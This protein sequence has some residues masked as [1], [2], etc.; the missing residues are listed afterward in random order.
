MHSH[1]FLVGSAHKRNAENEVDA[2][3]HGG[4]KFRAI[5][6][7]RGLQMFHLHL[8]RGHWTVDGA[9]GRTVA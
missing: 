2:Y 6:G 3:G 9:R 8:E 5:R 4:T 1:F 7:G